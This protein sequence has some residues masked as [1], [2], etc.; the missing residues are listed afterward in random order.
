MAD[1]NTISI[2]QKQAF[3]ILSCLLANGC[4]SPDSGA[5]WSDLILGA[6]SE[7]DLNNLIGALNAIA[8]SQ[9]EPHFLSD[10]PSESPGGAS[11]A[12]R[13]PVQRV[14]LSR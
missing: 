14:P 11:D 13:Y 5:K 4:L 2:L 3:G 12:N 9:T 10:S 7:A 8:A 6:T 1:S